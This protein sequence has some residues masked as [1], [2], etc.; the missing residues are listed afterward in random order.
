MYKG[1]RK[2]VRTGMKILSVTAGIIL[3]TAVMA[4]SA[5]Q[6]RGIELG[7]YEYTGSNEIKQIEYYES[8]RIRTTER[9]VVLTLEQLG[10]SD[11]ELA[12]G[13][14]VESPAITYT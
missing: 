7:P 8:E 13:E 12:G 2:M 4:T 9:S 14:E 10:Y 11:L 1:S 6:M 3:V 5:C